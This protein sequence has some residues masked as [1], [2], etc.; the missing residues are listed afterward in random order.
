VRN[1]SSRPTSVE[2]GRAAVEE[3][4]VNT[5]HPQ[6]TCVQRSEVRGKPNSKTVNTVPSDERMSSFSAVRRGHASRSGAEHRP[7]SM[8]N[9]HE[10]SRERS[11]VEDRIRQKHRSK[12]ERYN[13]HS[14]DTETELDKASVS[15]HRRNSRKQYGD[16]D[17]YA[18]AQTVSSRRQMKQ[19]KREER[20]S[21]KENYSSS[22]DRKFRPT[23]Q[24]RG[25]CRDDSNSNERRR[26]KRNEREHKYRSPSSNESKTRNTRRNNTVRR[27]K[28]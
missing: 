15:R 17:S 21:S 14:S 4:S 28:P 19:F 8:N 20:D 22:S 2:N 24:E 25:S 3:T 23:Q 1:R 5:R 10:T 11:S 12:R 7:S 18:F 16:E 26:H 9:R 6:M 13:S 27:M